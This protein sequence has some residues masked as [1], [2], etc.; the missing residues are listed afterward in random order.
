MAPLP[1]ALGLPRMESHGALLVAVHW[2]PSIT[3]TAMALSPPSVPKVSVAGVR[4][5]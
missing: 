5:N 3:D 1:V 2:Q 4:L